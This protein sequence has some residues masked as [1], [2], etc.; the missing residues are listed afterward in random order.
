MADQQ[1]GWYPDPSGDASKLR[2]W[3]GAQ[4]TNDFSDAQ[5]SSAAQPAQ[6]VQPVQPQVVVSETTYS[7]QTGGQQPINQPYMQA[8]A[9]Q[10]N[11][12]AIGA[13]ICGIAGLCTGG[14]LSIV[15]IILGVLG[16]KNPVNKGMATAGL[17]LGIVGIVLWVIIGIFY[18]A[19]IMAYL[20]Y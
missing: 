7:N 14:L 11:G 16:R 19:V 12:L 3:D 17:I 9:Q 6:P 5:T 13:L 18:G 2:Y 8:P 20:N 1:A 4:W 10:S 15:A